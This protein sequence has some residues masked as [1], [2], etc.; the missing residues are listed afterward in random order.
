[1]AAGAT[2]CSGETA[3]LTA[4]A[5]GTITWYS[6]PNGSSLVAT[7][8]SFTTPALSQNATYYVGQVDVATGCAS[9][10]TAVQVTVNALPATPSVTTPIE[11]CDG[12]NV[13]LEA[14]GSGGNLVFYDNNAVQLSSVVAGANNEASY[15]AGALAVG[16]YNFIVREDDG[17]CLSNPVAVAA[18]VNA[19]PAAPVAAGATIC[20]GNG[21][22]LSATGTSVQWYSDAALT[23]IIATG[24]AFTTPVLTTSTDYYVTQT[25]ADGCEG[26]ATTVPVTVDPL[27]AAPVAMNDTIC[28]GGTAT[29]TATATGTITWYSDPTGANIIATGASLTTAALAQNTTYYVG[30]V[31]VA[32]GCASNLAAVQ[33]IVNAQPLAPVASDVEVC[34]SAP[35]ILTATGSGTGE[36]VF[37]DNAGIEI[38]RLN[39]AGTATQSYTVGNLGAGT[40]LYTVVEDRGDCSSA[41][42]A[43]Q[44]TVKEVPNAPTTFNDSPVCEGEAVFVQASAIQGGSYFWT[45]PNGFSSTMANFSLPNATLAQAGTYSVVVTVNGCASTSASTTVTVSARPTLGAVSSN[46]PLCEGDT[47]NLTTANPST[48]LSYAWTGPNGFSATGS[49]ASVNGVSEIDNQG[50]YNLVATDGTTGCSSAP[51]STLVM[52]TTLPDAGMASSNS[53]ICVGD[54]LSLMV[55]SV[56]GATYAWEGP[57]G[58]T[59]TTSTPSITSATLDAEGSYSVTV[60]VGNCFSVY[61]TDVKVVEATSVDAGRDTIIT[62]GTPYRLQASGAAIYSWTP[63]TNLDNPNS[64]SPLFMAPNIGTYTFSVLGSTPGGCSATDE[65]MIEVVRPALQDIKIVDLFTPNGDGIND[66]WRV[67]F[68]QDA[69]VGPYTL[70]IITRGGIEVLN[71]QNYQNDWYG[72]LNGQNLPDGTYWYV[73]YFEQSQEVV[74]GAVTIKR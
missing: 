70:Q 64:S 67:D 50:F 71:T 72:T 9:A 15:N 35:V 26:T 55:N 48:S 53:P 28:A 5:A 59:A 58:F 73:I 3:T 39:M 29:L 40:Y 41:A 43:I 4:T 10:L 6:D 52:I 13:I 49:S 38:A 56:F 25:S 21:V 1:M 2:V 63:A 7:G 65:V 34:A 31:D 17:T 36:L 27:P 68:L 62:L 33:V 57:D 46:S 42:T 11:V 74:K 18:V 30:Q 60:T 54:D 12:E 20:A 37:Y 69:S 19:L 61:T 23:N 51:L 14:T 22:T 32:T 47:L 16:N 45:G 44:V 66:F 8:A 24:N